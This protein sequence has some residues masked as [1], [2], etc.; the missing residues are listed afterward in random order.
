MPLEEI[1]VFHLYSASEEKPLSREERKR[2]LEELRKKLAEIKEIRQKLGE[3]EPAV[4][5]PT[6]PVAPLPSTTASSNSLPLRQTPLR[7]K[8]H[9]STQEMPS[10]PAHS[11]QELASALEELRVPALELLQDNPS[12]KKSRMANSN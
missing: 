12:P 3:A 9:T 8:E 4:P 6:T 1:P 10:T 7:E 5:A 2:L 11:P